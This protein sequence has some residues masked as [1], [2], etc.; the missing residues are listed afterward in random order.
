M[1][2]ILAL[3][4]MLGVLG[5]LAAP[6]AAP[7]RARPDPGG[8]APGVGDD[9]MASAP[10][11]PTDQQFAWPVPGRLVVGF[12]PPPE[13]WSSGHRGVDLS[14]V[15][16]QA[17]HAMASGVV[18][19]AGMVAGRAWVSVDHPDGVRTTVGPLS[20]VGV[21]EGQVVRPGRVV[22]VAAATAHADATGPVTG[23]LHVSAR[24]DGAYVDP[25]TLVGSWVPSLVPN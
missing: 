14:V 9:R 24:V 8:G 19:F 11:G 21:E 12:D 10:V 2:R 4:L 16:G 3:V 13:P 6:V 18:G 17:V 25:A 1:T 15:H 5:V 23:L 20:V 7:A 22:G